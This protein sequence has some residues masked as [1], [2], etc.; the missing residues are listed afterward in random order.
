MRQRHGPLLFLLESPHVGDRVAM[1]VGLD[2]EALEHPP[3]VSAKLKPAP[4]RPVCGRTPQLLGCAERTLW[5]LW[6][7]KPQLHVADGMYGLREHQ[8]LLGRDAAARERP[9]EALQHDRKESPR[10]VL[11]RLHGGFRKVEP[12]LRHDGTVEA[13]VLR[14]TPVEI[15]VDVHALLCLAHCQLAVF[16]SRTDAILNH[17]HGVHLGLRDSLHHVQLEARAEETLEEAS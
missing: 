9:W 10:L 15:N 13:K 11:L 1:R 2:C 4:L 12:G 6:Q 3:Q 17:V 14:D 7:L 16:L 5:A 8:L